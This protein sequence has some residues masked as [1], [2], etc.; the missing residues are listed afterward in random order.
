MTDEIPEGL[1]IARD[2]AAKRRAERERARRDSKTVPLASVP[3][4]PPEPPDDPEQGP[5]EYQG[6]KRKRESEPEKPRLWNAL[7]LEA[8][9]QPSWLATNRLPRAAISLLIGDEGIGKSLL[10]VLVV[11][12]VTTG[13]PMVP[14]GVP[15]RDPGRVIL[16]TTEDD[17]ST[18]VRPRLE[19]AGADLAMIQVICTDPDGG[20]APVFPRD[21]SIIRNADPKPELVVVDCWLDTVPPQ[22][23]V[24]DPQQARQAL[25]P[26]KDV[27]TEIGAAI[28]LLCHSNRVASGNVRDRYGATYAL[29]QKARMTIWAMKDPDDDT[30]LAGPEKANGARISVATRFGVRPLAW[31]PSTDDQDGTVPL[32]ECQGLSD[33]TISDHVKDAADAAAQAAAEAGRVDPS[34][35]VAWLAEQLAGGP[36]WSVDINQAAERADVSAKRLATAKRKLNVDTDRVAGTGPWFMRLQ[37]HKGLEPGAQNAV[38]IPV[39]LDGNSGQSGKNQNPPVTRKDLQMSSSGSTGTPENDPVCGECGAQLTTPA[40]VRY[41]KC[42]ECRTDTSNRDGTGTEGQ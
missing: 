29:R 24:R 26:W 18:C 35:A 34:D 16:V 6:S 15:P 9:V 38:R 13:K 1:R 2:W 11:A 7:D 3:D 30:L 21:L 23:N 37:L 28:W 36:R 31:F 5:A 25:H 8:S 41:G 17:W 22:L 32:L 42:Q 27:A 12:R 39:L 33:R 20:G 19:V 14:F 4:L 10:W 40:S